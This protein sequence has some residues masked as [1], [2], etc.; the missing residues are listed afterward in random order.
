M[1]PV[2]SRRVL[3]EEESVDETELNVGSGASSSE[4]A[5]PEAMSFVVF[6]GVAAR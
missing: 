1:K 4:V 5:M 2:A 3:L 6:V